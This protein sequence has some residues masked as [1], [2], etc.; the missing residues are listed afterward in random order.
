MAKKKEVN[1]IEPFADG[2]IIPGGQVVGSF[3]KPIVIDHDMLEARILELESLVNAYNN[4]KQSE[5]TTESSILKYLKNKINL[6]ES[7]I[8]LE[9]RKREK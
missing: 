3:K 2:G 6:K 1:K 4:L 8:M 7:E 5:I 9:L